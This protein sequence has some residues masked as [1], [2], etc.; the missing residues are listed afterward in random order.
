MSSPTSGLWSVATTSL[1][2]PC[3][4][5][6]LCSSAHATASASPSMDAYLLSALE[7]NLEPAKQMRLCAAVGAQRF[8]LA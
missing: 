4:K 1:S 5:N 7:L 2:H 6:L 3:V 8:A